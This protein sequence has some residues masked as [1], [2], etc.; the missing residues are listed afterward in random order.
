MVDRSNVD[1]LTRKEANL[2]RAMVIREAV[3]RAVP[4]EE[5]VIP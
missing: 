1:V 3:K 2:S 5:S 4:H